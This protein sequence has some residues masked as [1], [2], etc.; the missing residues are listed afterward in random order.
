MK[1]RGEPNSKTWFNVGKM[2][3]LCW[4]VLQWPQNAEN[5]VVLKLEKGKTK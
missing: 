5:V 4:V 3:T 2:K 1:I